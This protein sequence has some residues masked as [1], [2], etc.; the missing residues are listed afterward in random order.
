MVTDFIGTYTIDVMKS[1]A[2]T[3][4]R[5]SFILGLQNNFNLALLFLLVAFIALCFI[6]AVSAES[7]N[8]NS[9]WS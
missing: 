7:K 4:M 2:E 8:N 9:R 3:Y 1:L 6:K 5:N